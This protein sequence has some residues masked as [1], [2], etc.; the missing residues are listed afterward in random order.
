MCLAPSKADPDAFAY[1]R[2][3][4]RGINLGNALDAPSEG[5]WGVRLKSEYFDAIRDAGFDSVRIPIRWS[6]HALE[7]PPY[8]IDPS[9]FERV[10]WAIEEAL[11]RNLAAV[12]NVHHYAEMN[13]EPRSHVER[14]I[15]LW[16][17]IAIRY[18]D[19]P[20]KLFFE[21]LNEPTDE[22][23]DDLWQQIFPEILKVIRESNRDRLVIIGPSSW[24][25]PQHLPAL[26]L[27]KEDRWLI[28][29]FH[30]YEPLHFTHQGASWV[31]NSGPWEGTTWGTDQ[32][33]KT[34]DSQFDA[35]ASWAH[36]NERPIYL[37]EFGSIGKADMTSR[38]SWTRTVARAAEVRGFSWSYWEFCSSFGI[39][40]PS[41][42]TW[43]RPLLAALLNK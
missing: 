22:L 18:R 27:P 32:E 25:S 23:S 9:F 29:T 6:A 37:G 7:S 33:H 36:Q 20:H 3:L 39:F 34:I 19:Q 14:L 11:S 21:L 30:Y 28:A 12:I 35:V 24:N 4:G 31:A 16:R 10:D 8:T 5:A 13:K 41:T 26:L 40:D 17:Q 43:K 38:A 1:N 2:M 42:K 15:A